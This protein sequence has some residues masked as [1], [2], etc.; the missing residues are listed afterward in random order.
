MSENNELEKF[1]SNLYNVCFSCLTILVGTSCIRLKRRGY[2]VKLCLV[3]VLKGNL[4]E[5]ILFLLELVLLNCFLFDC[6]FVC[7]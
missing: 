5:S 4:Q 1:S 7:F 2:P 3:H 6:L